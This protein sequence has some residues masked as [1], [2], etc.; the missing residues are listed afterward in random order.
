MAILDFYKTQNQKVLKIYIFFFTRKQENIW[1][2]TEYTILL[3]NIY[4]LQVRL[5]LGAKLLN[6]LP[7]HWLDT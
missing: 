3:R 1:K 4:V 2:Y 6:C 7:T 5:G